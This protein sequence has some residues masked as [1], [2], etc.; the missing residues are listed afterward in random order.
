MSKQV[1]AGF[2]FARLLHGIRRAV[3]RRDVAENGRYIRWHEN[4]DLAPQLITGSAS[5]VRG[6]KDAV[7]SKFSAEL[8]ILCSRVC[9]LA[10]GREE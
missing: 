2:Q 8:G 5:D 4:T 10:I 7:C 9:V 3:K 6:W 1:K